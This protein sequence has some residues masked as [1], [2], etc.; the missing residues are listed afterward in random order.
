MKKT[1]ILGGAPSSAK[2][3]KFTT[4]PFERP[5]LSEDEVQ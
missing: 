2:N 4:K 3:S 5:G 1:S